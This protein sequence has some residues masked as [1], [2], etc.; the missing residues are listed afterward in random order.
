[1]Q[2]TDKLLKRGQF[3]FLS[4]T[5]DS[6]ADRFFVVA[7]FENQLDRSRLGVTVTR[8]IGHA[9]LRNRIKRLVRQYFRTNRHRLGA[10]FD[11]NVIARK[12]AAG[13]SSKEVFASLERL[14][15]KIRES[16]H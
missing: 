6:V 15:C 2:K 4:R 12:S 14:F 8:K 16:C 13:A 1:M 3:V 7:Y 10:N 9:V 5:A 11:I